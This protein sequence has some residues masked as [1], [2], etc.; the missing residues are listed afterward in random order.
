MN[1]ILRF[2]LVF[3]V[4]AIGDVFWALYFIEIGKRNAGM[5]G[6]WSS[7]IMC[8]AGVTVLNYMHSPYLLIASVSGAFVGTYYTVK[9]KK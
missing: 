5:A 8:V 1:F 3:V 7:A 2:I 6:V 4:T 9:H